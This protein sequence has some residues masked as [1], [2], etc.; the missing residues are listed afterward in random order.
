MTSKP[1]WWT[2]GMAEKCGGVVP[3]PLSPA[4]TGL[5]AAWNDGDK[6]PLSPERLG[7]VLVL[8]DTWDDFPDAQWGVGADDSRTIRALVLGAVRDATV[9][10]EPRLAALSAAAREAVGA[11]EAA[12]T[13]LDEY[14]DEAG[15]CDHGVGI[16]RCD[17]AGTCR[18]VAEAV[19]RVRTALGD[20]K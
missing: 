17:I 1:E 9:P 11:L 10:A 2:S 8:C 20:C 12:G 3:E 16:C 18:L 6:A 15:P 19:S 14:R 13:L 5:D 4:P 7:S